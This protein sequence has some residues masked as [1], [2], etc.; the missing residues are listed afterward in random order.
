MMME[1]MPKKERE[2]KSVWKGKRRKN[3]FCAWP[4]LPSSADDKMVG[5]QWDLRVN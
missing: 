2:K 5:G 4:G 3:E 1:N